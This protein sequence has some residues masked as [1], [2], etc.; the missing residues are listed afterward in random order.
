MNRQASYLRS[1]KGFTLQENR[2]NSGG[3]ERAL[4]SDPLETEIAFQTATE[5]P[6]VLG[7]ESF[8]AP[9]YLPEHRRNAVGQ[10][11]GKAETEAR[12]LIRTAYRRSLT[13]S[14]SAVQEVRSRSRQVKEKNPLLLLGVIAMTAFLLGVG[15]RVWRSSRS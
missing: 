15:T 9:R 4:R 2:T 6:V 3:E 1:K 12:D 8:G 5:G 13:A 7:A 10:W 14:E 11:L